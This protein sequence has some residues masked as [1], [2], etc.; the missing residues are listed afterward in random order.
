MS[1][2]KTVRIE[3]KLVRVFLKNDNK[4]KFF[5]VKAAFESAC[6]KHGLPM[7]VV[8]GTPGRL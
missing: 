3:E 8:I 1:I 7:G 6:R 5:C 2:L 4:E